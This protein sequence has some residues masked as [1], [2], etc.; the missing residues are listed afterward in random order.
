MNVIEVRDLAKGFWVPSV[1]RTT[2]REHLLGLLEP[3][4]FRRLNV[5]RSV[6]FEIARGESVALVGRNGSGK[7][8]LLKLLC[9]IY[10]ADSGCVSVRSPLTPIIELGAGWSP[11]LDALDNI[12]LLG[13][14]MG[15]TLREAQAATDAILAFAE[16]ESFARLSLKHFSSGMAARLAY[17]V[18]FHAARDVL[19]LDEIYAV[20]DA[21]FR[22][23]CQ[24]RYSQLKQAGHTMIMVSHDPDAVAL[25]DRALLLEDGRIEASGSPQEILRRHMHNAT[26]AAGG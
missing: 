10:V 26:R 4:S 13:T 25:C 16:L 7:S 15:M 12:L 21:R 11:E 6:S 8:T 9:G 24:E 14:V 5:L 20:G 2:L 17:A 23:R 19:L 1:G 3:R 18:A 22:A